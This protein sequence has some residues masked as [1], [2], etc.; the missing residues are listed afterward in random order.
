MPDIQLRINCRAWPSASRGWIEIGVLA[1][2]VNCADPSPWT[3]TVPGTRLMSPGPSKPI[4]PGLPIM[5]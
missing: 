5:P 2:I 4:V 1:E 3:G